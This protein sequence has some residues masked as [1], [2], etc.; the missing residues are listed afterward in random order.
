MPDTHLCH[1]LDVG[2]TRAA[3]CLAPDVDSALELDASRYRVARGGHDKRGHVV[4][5]QAPLQ[6]VQSLAGLDVPH[7]VHHAP[8]TGRKGE[9][10]TAVWVDGK[11]AY[12]I[13][14]G[15]PPDR[16][17]RGAIPH[18][19]VSSVQGEDPRAPAR[20]V[21]LHQ[22]VRRRAHE[23]QF[24]QTRAAF[25]EGEHVLVGDQDLLAAR[26]HRHV[27][28]QHA[29]RQ[30]VQHPSIGG[31]PDPELPPC[32]RA[33]D[34]HEVVREHPDMR[35]KGQPPEDNRLQER[36][37]A[38]APDYGGLVRGQ[39]DNA[40][41]V[42]KGLRDAHVLATELHLYGLCD[43]PQDGAP[44][45]IQRAAVITRNA[46]R[47]QSPPPR[48]EGYAATR[49]SGYLLKAWPEAHPI[50]V[51]GVRDQGRQRRHYA[52]DDL[53]RQTAPRLG[54]FRRGSQR[55][56]PAKGDKRETER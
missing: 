47:Q 50:C 43:A 24:Q 49:R 51:I 9:H 46:R 56:D 37:R 18:K 21:H 6:T 7:Q 3:V 25:P 36:P 38:G 16:L 10:F 30:R 14:H 28:P 54:H 4:G 39:A 42:G 2:V 53:W 17:P 8:D 15:Y 32:R 11:V 48:Q 22:V 44:S 26:G 40:L 29:P 41:S 34:E 5:S 35:V 55:V 12:H 1:Q 23:L 52:P 19:D 33:Q 31:I 20:H 13:L 45:S 27:L